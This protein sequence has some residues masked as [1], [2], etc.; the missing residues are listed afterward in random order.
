MS[1]F[2]IFEAPIHTANELRHNGRDLNLKE[3]INSFPIR[4]LHDK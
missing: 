3:S 1:E 2:K 4:A